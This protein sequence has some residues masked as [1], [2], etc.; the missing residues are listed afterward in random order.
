MFANAMQR[1]RT[2]ADDREL[3][4]ERLANSASDGLT[5]QTKKTT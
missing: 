4:E 1:T 3:F 5:K 2:A